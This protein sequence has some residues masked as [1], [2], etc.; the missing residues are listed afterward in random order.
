MVIKEKISLNT[1]IPG[2]RI[3]IVRD[4]GAKPPQAEA[5]KLLNLGCQN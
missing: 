2:I 3:T 1:W 4:A 5:A